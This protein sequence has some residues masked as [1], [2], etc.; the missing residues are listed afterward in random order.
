MTLVTVQCHNELYGFTTSLHVWFYNLFGIL[1][2]KKR[3]GEMC[4][5]VAPIPC[6]TS[7]GHVRALII[8]HVTD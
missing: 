3:S 5:V 1:H 8:R 4:S 6:K 7:I 2:R